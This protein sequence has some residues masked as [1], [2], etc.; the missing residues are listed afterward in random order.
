MRQDSPYGRVDEGYEWEAWDGPGEPQ[1][2]AGQVGAHLNSPHSKGL[3][4]LGL[5]IELQIIWQSRTNTD[6]WTFQLSHWLAVVFAIFHAV[7]IYEI[8]KRY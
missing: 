3:K 8:H 1:V 7:N 5:E 2:N 6:F 4:G